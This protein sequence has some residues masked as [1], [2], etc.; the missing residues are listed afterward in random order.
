MKNS[1]MGLILLFCFS[2][3][4]QVEGAYINLKTF[5]AFGFGGH[6][7]FKFPINEAASLTTEAGLY[8]FK[9]EETHVA[10]APVLLGYQ[11]TINGSGTGLFVEPLAGYTFGGTDITK[12]DEEGR[13]IYLV[14]NG[15]AE[16]VNQSVKGIT[17]GLATGYIFDGRTPIT[18][19][20]R[21][22]RVFV[23]GD[24]AVNLVGLRISWP[25]FGGSRD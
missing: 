14:N 22:E 13:E 25:L 3:N 9:K 18:L 6:L 1:L 7:N 10:T 2:A 11:Y 15:V 8:Y 20:V 4:A 5:K 23:S 19:G 12:V 24:P 17:A 16:T 21:Y